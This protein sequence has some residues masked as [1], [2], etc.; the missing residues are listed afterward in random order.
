MWEVLHRGRIGTTVPLFAGAC[1]GFTPAWG[2]ALAF[3]VSSSP[4]DAWWI[5]G[6]AKKYRSMVYP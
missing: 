2:G 3:N 4:S 5:V 1:A 6:S